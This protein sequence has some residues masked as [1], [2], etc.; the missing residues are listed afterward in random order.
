MAFDYQ[1][2]Q[3]VNSGT[4]H[5]NVNPWLYFLL[6]NQRSYEMMSLPALCSFFVCVLLLL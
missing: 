6:D 5:V 1:G 3:D 4:H 2:K